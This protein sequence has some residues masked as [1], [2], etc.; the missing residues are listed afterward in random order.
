M[1]VPPII[2][3][4]VGTEA[5]GLPCILRQRLLALFTPPDIVMLP[6]MYK[7][8]QCRDLDAQL[9]RYFLVL[10]ARR[11]HVQNRSFLFFRHRKNLLSPGS[12]ERKQK[13][14]FSYTVS[15]Y[16]TANSGFEFIKAFSLAVCFSD[17]EA[18][19]FAPPAV[20][21]Y[22]PIEQSLYLHPNADDSKPI[23]CHNNSF[24]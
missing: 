11:P 14:T 23:Q 12:R 1:A 5:L 2:T 3:A 4:L 8:L 20:L 10:L 15:A 22:S 6:P 17:S 19:P 24:H 7:H 13:G 18:A 16:I 21:V 9:R